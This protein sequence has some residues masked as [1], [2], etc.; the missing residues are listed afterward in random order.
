MSATSGHNL[1]HARSPV[2]ARQRTLERITRAYGVLTVEDLRA[3]AR[4]ETWEVPFATVLLRATRAGRLR[5]LS[6]E[7]VAVPRHRR[8]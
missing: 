5:R 6:A 2:V 7:L 8:Q 3:L 1:I 4:A